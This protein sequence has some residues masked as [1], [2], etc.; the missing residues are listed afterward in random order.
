MPISDAKAFSRSTIFRVILEFGY[1]Y[2]R[3]YWYIHILSFLLSPLWFTFS[4]SLYILDFL[5]V[6]SFS[7]P[8]DSSIFFTCHFLLAKT[9]P[10]QR[11]GAASE[12]KKVSMYHEIFLFLIEGTC[13]RCRSVFSFYNSSHLS[14]FPK[15]FTCTGR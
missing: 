13:V 6:P 14:T 5:I 7:F 12:I 10:W 4:S 8:F 3:I 2:I 9:I 1:Y 15:L 11:C